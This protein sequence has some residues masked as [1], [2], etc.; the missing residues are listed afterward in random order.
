MTAVEMTTRELEMPSR[1]K[2]GIKAKSIIVATDGSETALAA[3]KMAAMIASRLSATIHVLTVLEP[4]P[5]MFPSVEG[6]IMPPELDR[7]REEAQRAIVGEQI[8]ANPAVKI[9]LDALKEWRM[10]LRSLGLQPEE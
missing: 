4:M 9:R 10:S 3:F 6:I 5:A 8:K 7:S 1:L 2:P